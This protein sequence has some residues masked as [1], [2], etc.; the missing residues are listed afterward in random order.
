MLCSLTIEQVL[1]FGLEHP[2]LLL[3][4]E[5]VTTFIGKVSVVAE[6]I[7]ILSFDNIVD[8]VHYNKVSHLL[9]KNSYYIHQL[10]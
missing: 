10:Y 5:S 9:L 8:H 7:S 1:V 2:F 4:D 3:D 6:S